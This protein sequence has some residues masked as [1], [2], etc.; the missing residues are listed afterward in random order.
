MF[1]VLALFYAQNLLVKKKKKNRPEIVPITS[2]YY[3]TSHYTILLGPSKSMHKPIYLK[4]VFSYL[5]V[6]FCFLLLTCL[7]DIF[8]IIYDLQKI[9]RTQLNRINSNGSDLQ[10]MNRTQ[11]NG[12]SDLQKM[13]RTQ[14]NRINSNVEV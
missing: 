1:S 5:T 13:N 3:A 8:K 11:L 10:K 7:C 2:L 6:Y 14:L 4:G 9:N 12:I